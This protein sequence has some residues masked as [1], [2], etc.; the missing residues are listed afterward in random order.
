MLW[1]VLLWLWLGS[2]PLLSPPPPIEGQIDHILVDKSARLM[3]LYQNGR[4][5]RAWHVAL[6]FDPEGAKTRQGDGKTP[7]G[8]FRID[9]RNGGSAFHLSLGIDYPQQTHRA[10]A[11]AGGVSPG[12][13]I[14]FHG[15]PNAMP[16][17]Y[18]MRGDW[19][20]GCIAL[21]N[22][23]IEELWRVTPVGTTVEI[24]P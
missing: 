8:H 2:P 14:F 9:R 3:V 6:G 19:T 12:G 24:R 16:D 10:A 7:E 20:E 15:Q 13:D 22:S 17:G 23:Q 5:V 21:T 11:R 1:A 18:M 4:P